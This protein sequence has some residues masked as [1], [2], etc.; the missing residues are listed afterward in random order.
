MHAST[1]LSRE[2]QQNEDETKEKN[3][4]DDIA[5][6]QKSGHHRFVSAVSSSQG[7]VSE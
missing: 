4:D 7:K 6:I 2:G 1:I 3:R 5:C